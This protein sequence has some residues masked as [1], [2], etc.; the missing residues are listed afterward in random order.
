MKLALLLGLLLAG[1][2]PASRPGDDWTVEDVAFAA[3]CDGSTQRYVLMLPKGFAAAEEHDVLIALHG[4]GSDRWQ[5]AKDP[6]DE[7]RAARD[8]AA[9]HHMIFVSPDYRAKTSWMGPKAEA[10]VV[11]IIGDLRSRYRVGRVVICGGSMGGASCL[12]FAVRHPEL[13][14]GVASMNGTANHL[15]YERFQ[16]AIRESFG[17]GKAD[18]P[19]EYKNRSAE[20]WPER[21]TMPVGITAGGKDA[22]VPPQSVVRLADV[23][24]KMGRPVLLIYRETGG[25]STSYEHARRILDHAIGRVAAEASPT[26]LLLDS[27]VVEKVENARLVPGTVRKDP[28]NPL[29]VEDRP[30]EP[31]FDNLYANVLYDE[32]E[33]VYKCWYSPFLIDEAVTRTPPERRK[34]LSYMDALHG[35]ERYMGVCYAVSPDGLK[36]TKPSLGLVDFEG[37]RA[38]NIVLRDVHGA[39]IFKDT[40]ETDPARR[41]KLFGKLGDDSSPMGVAFSPDGLKWSKPIARPEMRAAGDTHNNAHWNESLGL[42]VGITRLFDGQRLVGRCVSQDFVSWSRAEAVLGGNPD[43]QTYAMPVFAFA[44]VYLGLVMILDAATDF[45]DCELAWS[46]DGVHWERVGEGEPLIPRGPAGSFDH[47]C[48]F[49]AAFPVVREG[50]IRLYYGGSDGPHG[51]WRKGGFGLA[52]LRPDGFAGYAPSEGG[53]AGIVLTRPLPWSGDSVRV[54]ADARGGALR[55]A[56]VDGDGTVLGRSRWIET[57]VTDAP[58]AWEDGG[59]SLKADGK[60]VR[61]RFEFRSARLYSFRLGNG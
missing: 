29:F 50:E 45:V 14:A 13:I 51:G 49:A 36:W 56:V 25:H 44:N 23:L 38:N 2:E 47:G 60:T 54:T 39:G 12:T 61:L 1:N 5:F 16:D 19:L 28:A 24:R 48:V 7:C 46:P 37:S 53:R 41:Y 35:N 42:Y 11:Q 18:V 40:R 30:W 43:R 4:H 57:D 17:G 15:E 26:R 52:R 20:Y 22:S 27:R 55:V 32:Q 58:I 34:T 10:D 9:A 33:R 8:A 21:L 3:D 31:R 59:A 6:R